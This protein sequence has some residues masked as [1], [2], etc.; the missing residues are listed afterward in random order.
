MT[1]YLIV[2]IIVMALLLSQ[3]SVIDFFLASVQLA[4]NKFSG[5]ISLPI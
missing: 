4:Y 1:E 2:L 5:F 3:P